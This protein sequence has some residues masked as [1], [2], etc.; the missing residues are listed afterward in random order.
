MPQKSKIELTGQKFGKLTVIEPIEKRVGGWV[1]KCKCD[2]GNE[3]EANVSKLRRGKKKSCGCGVDGKNNYGWKGYEEIMGTVWNH[4]GIHAKQRKIMLD[5][6]IKDG[7][8]LFKKQNR[9]CALSGVLLYFAKTAKE[10]RS[11]KQTASL[12]RIDSSK[13]YTKDNV[14][15][16]HKD[17]NLMKWDWNQHEFLNW[18]KLVT[19][20][21]NEKENTK[22][23]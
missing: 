5:I 11:K 15:W 1:W 10:L 8:E 7:W 6:T 20:Y 23:N 19:T 12:D 4:I 3:T 14:Q 2:C 9:R 16:I 22:S 18:C 17:L 21:Q 13:G